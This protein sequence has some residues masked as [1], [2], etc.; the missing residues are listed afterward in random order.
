MKPNSHKVFLGTKNWKLWPDFPWRVL[1]QNS[2][3][4]H[5]LLMIFPR[6]SMAY[7]KV[8]CKVSES[9]PFRKLTHKRTLTSNRN[10]FWVQFCS[11]LKQRGIDCVKYTTCSLGFRYLKVQSRVP[12]LRDSVYFCVTFLFPPLAMSRIFFRI[13][14][15]RSCPILNCT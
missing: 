12:Q 14:F 4:R 5:E 9:T 6:V 3:Q 11:E 7:N 15:P 1:V 8:P 2:R 13:F 10:W